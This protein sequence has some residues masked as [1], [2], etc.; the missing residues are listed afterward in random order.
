M[1]WV[2][3]KKGEKKKKQPTIIIWILEYL[4]AP[5][6]SAPQASCFSGFYLV[7][8]L[9]QGS[10]DSVANMTENIVMRC[11]GDKLQSQANILPADTDGGRAGEIGLWVR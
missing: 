1:L 11:A 2:W 10:G 9:P 6:N 3:L 5:L 8:A 4:G 7:P